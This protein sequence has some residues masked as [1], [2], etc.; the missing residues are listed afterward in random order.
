M[1]LAWNTTLIELKI[2]VNVKE[3]AWKNIETANHLTE[4]Y[5]KRR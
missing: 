3:K 1:Q 4:K 5:G 2:E